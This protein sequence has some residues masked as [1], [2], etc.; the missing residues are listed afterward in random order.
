MAPAKPTAE[1]LKT[2]WNVRYRYSQSTELRDPKAAS[3]LE[4][5]LQYLPRQGSALDLAC[6]RGGNAAL[7]HKQGLATHAWDISEVV[8]AELQQRLPDVMAEVRD[9]VAE[10]PEANRFDVIVVSRFLERSLCSAIEAALKPGGVL[11]YQ[12]LT[13]GLKNPDYLL[14]PNELLTLFP[15][16]RVQFYEEPIDGVDAALISTRMA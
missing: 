13:H 2:K 9:V 8:V 3:V 1:E 6:G 12:T 5:H 4:E 16:L 10:P 7:L 11:F 14:A 15:T